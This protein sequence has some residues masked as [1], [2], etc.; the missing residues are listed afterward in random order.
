MMHHQLGT[1]TGENPGYP[2]QRQLYRQQLQY[3]NVKVIIHE[4]QFPFELI[5]HVL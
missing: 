4:N 2:S 5:T 3:P 1:G